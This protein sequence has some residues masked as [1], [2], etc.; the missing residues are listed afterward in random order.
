MVAASMRRSNQPG[1]RLCP[2]LASCCLGQAQRRSS[3]RT[4]FRPE[5]ECFIVKRPRY[6][7]LPEEL[8]RFDAH[9]NCA[10]ASSSSDVQIGSPSGGP[11]FHGTAISA[12]ARTSIARKKSYSRR[13]TLHVV[14]VTVASKHCPRF[15]GKF[16][17]RYALCPV[18]ISCRHLPPE[19]KSPTDSVAGHFPYV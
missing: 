13:I 17:N 2:I 7:R 19:M 6:R 9:S 10:G 8:R 3:V 15:G 1:R 12:F 16:V 14:C 18:E 11:T 5:P 4:R